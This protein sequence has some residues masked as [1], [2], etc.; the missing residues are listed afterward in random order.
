MFGFHIYCVKYTYIH[1]SDFCM[2]LLWDEEAKA[3][4]QLKV[5]MLL[6]FCPHMQ[7]SGQPHDWQ[8]LCVHLRHHSANPHTG[9][10]ET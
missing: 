2:G 3:L 9:H 5:E 10:Y 6:P 4:I 8:R 1:T 7:Q